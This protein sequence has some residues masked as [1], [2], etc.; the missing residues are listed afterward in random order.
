MHLPRPLLV[1]N[2][3]HQIIINISIPPAPT[4]LPTM[5]PPSILPLIA[6]V[7]SLPPAHAWGALPHRTIALLST[8]FLLPE[9]AAFIRTI[10]PKDESISAAAIWGDYF[11]HTPEGRWSGPLHYID[12]HDDPENGVCGVDFTRDCGPKGMCVVGGIVNMVRYLIF[13]SFPCSFGFC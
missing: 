11:S 9:T 3:H 2:P 1:D 10:L 13:Y 5:I 6:L 7:T 12:A 8:R 4:H